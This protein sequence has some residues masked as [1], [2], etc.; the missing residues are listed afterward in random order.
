VAIGYGLRMSKTD[1]PI[2]ADP[3]MERL[4]TSATVITFV[5]TLISLG[6]ALAAVRQESLTLLVTGLIVYWVGD[7]LDGEV[8][9]WRNCETR[10]GAVIDMLC[11]R[12]NCAGFYL[13]LAWLQPIMAI[14]VSVYLFEFMVI[15]MF[16]SMAFLAWPI[17]SPNYFYA[18]NHRI[19]VWNWS[20]PGK[21]A[22][23]GLFAVLLLVTGW[24]W[25]GL[26]I[27]LGLLTLKCVSLRWLLQLGIPLPTGSIEQSA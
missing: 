17:R 11:D 9:R 24:W 12:L 14:P 26:I 27:A 10:T 16:L 22:N 19:W 13:G 4:F 6:F 15:D 25:L 1:R 5:R 18:V 20:R 21:A 3:S 8:A 23:S 7:T 2:H